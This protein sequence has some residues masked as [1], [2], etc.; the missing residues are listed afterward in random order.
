MFITRSP[1]KVANLLRIA[2]FGTIDSGRE[3]HQTTASPIIAESN[4]PNFRYARSEVPYTVR[5]Y[6]VSARFHPI[7]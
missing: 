5:I 7:S 6:T 3:Q 1:A 2:L 4:P